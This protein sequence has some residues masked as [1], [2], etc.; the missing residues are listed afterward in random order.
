MTTSPLRAEIITLA[1]ICQYLSLHYSRKHA[2]CL[3]Y[4]NILYH[5]MQKVWRKHLKV[6]C[7]NHDIQHSRS[8]PVVWP[9]RWWECQPRGVGSFTHKAP[10]H[11]KKRAK[12]TDK[13]CFVLIKRLTSG[14]FCE[15][16]S[17]TKIQVDVHNAFTGLPIRIET[18]LLTSMSSVS[19]G[20]WWGGK[21]T[22]FQITK[23]T[24]NIGETPARDHLSLH[25]WKNL[26]WLSQPRHI[27]GSQESP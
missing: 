11:Q 9:R 18:V 14:S 19:Y 5:N 24:V 8:T 2:P 20:N 4:H 21:V 12:S 27:W 6:I 10:D 7:L 26:I 13:V 15:Q 22:G 3:L 16:W 25:V 23:L 17:K 1:K